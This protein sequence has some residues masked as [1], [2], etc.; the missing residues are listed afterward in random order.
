[1]SQIFIYIADKLWPVFLAV[2]VTQWAVQKFVEMRKPSLEMVPEGESYSGTWG[3]S[4]GSTGGGYSGPVTSVTAPSANISGGYAPST[5]ANMSP[6][7]SGIPVGKSGGRPFH[8]WRIKVQQTEIPCYLRRL[9]KSREPALHCEAVLSFY[10]SQGKDVFTMQG[11]WAKTP[12]PSL[13]HHGQER[14]I[15]PDTIDIGY[16]APR[17]LDCIHKFDVE[18]DTYGWNNE[19]Y[20]K[21]ADGKYHKHKL[22]VGAYTVDVTL[23]GPNV[24][25][26]TTK[27]KIEISEDW[28]KTS[29]TLA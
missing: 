12:E 26:F 24:R 10:D 19:S 7:Y 6:G 22:G 4:V 18:K 20:L 28:Q 17:I 16:H 3:P 1:M 25:V 29:L 8:A 14:I 27:F 21:E 9:V 2:G 13:V 11:R 15:Y 5:S 23:S